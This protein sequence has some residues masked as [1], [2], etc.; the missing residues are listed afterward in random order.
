MSGFSATWL[1]LRSGADDRARSV[2]LEQRL[3]PWLRARLAAA[4]GTPLVCVDLACG[5]GANLRRLAPRL[6]GPQR[7]RAVDADESLL[8]HVARAAAT[9]RD[10]D[11]DGTTIEVRRR[12]LAAVPLATEVD[13]AAL[14]TASALLDLVSG[15]WLDALA[16][17]L[18][19]A[20]AAGLFALDYDGRRECEPADAFDARAHAA[21]ER[22]QRTEK[23]FGPALGG[24]AVVRAAQAFAARG[25]DVYRARSDWLLGPSDAALQRELLQGWAEAAGESEPDARDEVDAWLERRLAH[26]ACGASR[27]RVGHEDLLVLPP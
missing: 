22:H 23:G 15:A 12:D 1:A 10:G 20:N 19:D 6:P 8:A 9:L 24:D 4:P 3:A 17:A 21:F 18:R 27:L 7:W 13:G 2:A 5:T 25:Y 16:D 14:V 11:G 26:V